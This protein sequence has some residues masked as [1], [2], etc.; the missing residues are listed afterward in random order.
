MGEMIFLFLLLVVC[1]LSFRMTF[2]FPV[3]LLDKSGGAS[4]FPRIII[5]ALASFIIIRII[6]I[7]IRKE[8]TQFI[9]K[10]LFT[11]ERGFFFISFLVYV[12]CLNFLG[13]VLSTI[14]FL[15]VT[16]SVFFNIT[17]GFYGT[18]KH[19]I[20]RIIAVVVFSFL[21]YFFFGKI[22]NI[23]L[24]TGVFSNLF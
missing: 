3:S 2:D 12:I 7:L 11:K 17:T 10:E 5:I 16:I 20:R 19:K 24:P 4:L 9:F 8:K 1:A 13:Y 22:I 6:Q 14:L 23:L 18:K 21:M 15:S